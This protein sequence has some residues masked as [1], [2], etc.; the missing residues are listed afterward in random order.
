MA[1]AESEKKRIQRALNEQGRKK[2]RKPP[3]WFH[4]NA[5]QRAYQRELRNYAKIFENT[6][7]D[8]FFPV[9][10]Q[11]EQQALVNLPTTD[12]HDVFK[13]MPKMDDWSED[14]QRYLLAAENLFNNRKPNEVQLAQQSAQEVN[15]YNEGQF[16]KINKSVLGVN[17]IAAE[18]WL[19][20]QINSYVAENVTL[21]KSI[22]EQGFKNVEGIVQRGFA[23]GRRAEDVQKDL[24]SQFGVTKRRGELIAR[25]Q[26]SKLNGNLTKY[27]QQEV[28]IKRFIWQTSGDERVRSAHAALNGKEYNWDEGAPGGIFPGGPILCR[29][30]SSPLFDDLL[31]E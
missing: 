30:G 23:A 1:L 8:I 12:G 20:G 22:P 25:D 10:P 21:I 5:A 17:I 2:L 3:K 14:I 18:P 4:P 9:L 6:I 29:C 31:D 24:V 7:R 28:G 27:R 15:Q 16:Q 13:S 26:V 19:Q 11:L